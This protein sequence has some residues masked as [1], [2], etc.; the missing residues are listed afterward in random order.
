MI[1]Y[2]RYLLCE[3][4]VVI[5]R[6]PLGMGIF[7]TGLVDCRNFSAVLKNILVVDDNE[8]LR[9]I[10][11]FHLRKLGW[12]ATSAGSGREAI[13]SVRCVNYD[14]ILIDINMPDMDGYKTAVDIRSLEQELARDPVIIVAHTA[15][16][17]DRDKCLAAG[18][19][20]GI[21]K[22]KLVDDLRCLVQKWLEQ[23][24]R[25]S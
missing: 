15:G 14:L 6:L 17:L 22:Q 5:K 10:L 2:R 9:H 8:S 20:D 12:E 23:S 4:C 1:V 18:M 13:Q 21:E 16:D 25:G 3:G 24:P 7:A 19:N 11:I